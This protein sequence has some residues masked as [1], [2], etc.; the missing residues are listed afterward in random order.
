MSLWSLCLCLGLCLGLCLCLGLSLVCVRVSTCVFLDLSLR[1][2]GAAITLSDRRHRLRRRHLQC[3]PLAALQSEAAVTSVDVDVVAALVSVSAMTTATDGRRR[4]SVWQPVSLVSVCVPVC[5]LVCLC[6]SLSP[7]HACPY[8]RVSALVY[9][10]S[11][12]L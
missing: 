7:F 4:H 5:R 9:V 12:S 6:P 3:V 2:T 11:L 1:L 10:C 8:V